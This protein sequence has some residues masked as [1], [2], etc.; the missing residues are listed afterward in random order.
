MNRY[1]IP[2]YL[3]NSIYE[4]DFNK[5]KELGYENVFV[6]LDNTLASPYDYL[7]EQKTIDLI[8]RIKSYS[9]NVTIISNNH[10]ERVNKFATPLNIKYLFEVKKPQTKK[11]KKY[12]IENNIDFNRSI[13]IGDQV[14]TDVN[15]ANHLNIDVILVKPL[16]SNDEPITFFPR[17]LDKH[18][19]RIIYKRNLSKEF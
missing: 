18:F 1:L 14:M 15:I 9:L 11:L 7:P 2:K 10:E 6:D 3:A 8:N 4:I 16:T 12:L 19:R 17:L 5:I 13:I